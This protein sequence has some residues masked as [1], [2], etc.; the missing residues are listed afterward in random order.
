[1]ENKDRQKLMQM[2][3]HCEDVAS[4]IR[5]CGCD[6]SCFVSD[7]LYFNA[8]AMSILQIGELANSLSE[9]FREKTKSDMPWGM[10]RG[11][12][13]WLAHAYGEI[14]DD[15]IWDTANHDIPKVLNFC[16]RMLESE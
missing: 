16:V 3:R 15:V 7:R 5:R 6:K 2:K 13:N 9:D 14:D 12:R 11:M 1:M 10:I 4:F 8:A